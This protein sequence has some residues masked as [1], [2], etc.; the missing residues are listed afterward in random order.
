MLMW[1]E[2]YIC[3]WGPSFGNWISVSRSRPPCFRWSDIPAPGMEHVTS[4]LA[5]Q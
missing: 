4:T 3:S 5:N 2:D 1:N